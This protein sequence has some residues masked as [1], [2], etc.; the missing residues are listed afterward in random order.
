MC[1]NGEPTDTV[2]S[3]KNRRDSSAER[4]GKA[5]SLFQGTS[6]CA[7]QSLHPLLY[8]PSILLALLDRT[9]R[10]NGQEETVPLQAKQILD[11]NDF[12]KEAVGQPYKAALNFFAPLA[13]I[14][15][16]Y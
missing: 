12:Q 15:S 9:T 16:A 7:P 8:G 3:N 2:D 10:G 11:G 14:R 4:V 6:G 13:N 5:I 1:S